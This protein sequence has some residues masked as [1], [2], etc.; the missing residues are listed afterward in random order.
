MLD[1]VEGQAINRIWG[2]NKDR[3]W[4]TA[5]KGALG[6]TLGASGAFSAIAALFCLQS[7][8]IPPT[9][10][11]E[12]QDPA[13]GGLEIVTGDVRRLHGS[14]ALVNR[15]RARGERQSDYR[16]AVG[17]TADDADDADVS[18]EARCGRTNP[19]LP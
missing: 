12:Q 19:P 4:V 11:L 8:L 17:L 3:L 9:L 15:V 10:N 13:C 16:R 2:P 6:H 7:G 1:A 5:I 14:K 18:A